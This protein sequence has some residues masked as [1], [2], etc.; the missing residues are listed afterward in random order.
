VAEVV[1]LAA[2]LI[3]QSGTALKVVED[4][5]AEISADHN[6]PTALASGK[7]KRMPEGFIPPG[8]L[9][10]PITEEQH[11]QIVAAAADDAAAG[12]ST[13]ADFIARLGK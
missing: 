4:V 12:N 13:A 3:G 11:A 10:K 7:M 8:I 5:K 9:E 6:T 1:Q 2:A